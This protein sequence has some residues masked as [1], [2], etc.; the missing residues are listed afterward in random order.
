MDRKPSALKKKT[1]V[2]RNREPS[3]SVDALTAGIHQISVGHASVGGLHFYF[4]Y[5]FPVLVKTLNFDTDGKKRVI[6]DFHVATLASDKFHVKVEANQTLSLSCLVPNTLYHP[7]RI[8]HEQPSPYKQNSVDLAHDIFNEVNQHYGTNP[9]LSTPQLVQ[10]PIEVEERIE[11][12]QIIWEQGD[13][14]LIAVQGQF[15]PIL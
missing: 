11:S 8:E 2:P 1:T 5:E 14:G 13:L 6:L 4:K 9:R 10:L 3:G 7:R 15:M 12:K